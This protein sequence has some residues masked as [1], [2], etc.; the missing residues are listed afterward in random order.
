MDKSSMRRKEMSKGAVEE[1]RS[2]LRAGARCLM[3]SEAD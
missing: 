3:R 1:V 2:T